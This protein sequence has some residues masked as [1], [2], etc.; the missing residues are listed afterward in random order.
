MV[1]VKRR[2]NSTIFRN[3]HCRRGTTVKR[4]AESNNLFAAIVKEATFS[5]FSLASAPEFTINRL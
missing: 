2:L 5:A 1:Q 3:C 4:I